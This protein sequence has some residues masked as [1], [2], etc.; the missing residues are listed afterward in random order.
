MTLPSNNADQIFCF[1]PD[2]SLLASRGANNTIDVWDLRRIRE[3][4]AAM[5]LDWDLPPY[6]AAGEAVGIEP[7]H[8][9][10]E[11]GEFAEAY[12]QRATENSRHMNYERAI[13]DYRRF[14]E[15]RPDD[16]SGYNNLAWLLA[17]WPADS[18]RP[19]EALPLALKA[20]EL[21]P[22]SGIYLNTLGVVYY[23][24]GQF[25][26][27]VN[28]L[29]EASKHQQDG[30]TAWD[31]FFLAMSFHELNEPEKARDSYARAIYWRETH[32]QIPAN[33]QDELRDFRTEADVL[34]AG[35]AEK[36]R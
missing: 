29:E 17:N 33:E 10:V 26:Q 9:E 24:L 13:A 11:F 34:L 35:P 8:A 25:E 28:A 36:Q 27:A 5:H 16:P 6:P 7:L 18:R 2:G 12:F 15:L 3:Q 22:K 21:A 20:I 14:L 23:R 32:P 19:D 1:S 30:S 31:F 4:L